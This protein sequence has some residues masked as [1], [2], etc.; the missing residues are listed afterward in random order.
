MPHR[1]KNMQYACW[2]KATLINKIFS[3]ENQL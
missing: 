3:D 1:Y 2:N